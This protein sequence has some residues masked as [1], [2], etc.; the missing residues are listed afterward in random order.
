MIALGFCWMGGIRLI[1]IG[2]DKDGEVGV[3]QLVDGDIIEGLIGLMGCLRG[4][5]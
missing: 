2:S 4:S 3:K 5:L 1:V